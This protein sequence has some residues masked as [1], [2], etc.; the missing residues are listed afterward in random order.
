MSHSMQKSVQELEG[1]D[2]GE[3]NYDSYLVITIH[4]LRRKP[5]DQFTHEDLR[6]MIAQGVGLKFLMPLAIEV[7]QRDALAS[8]DLYPGDLLAAVSKVE[9]RFWRCHADWYEAVRLILRR[10][11]DESPSETVSDILREASAFANL[12]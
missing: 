10:A 6:I 1:K 9:E 2:W 11:R 12:D 5:L 4:R 3:P 7:L 8:G